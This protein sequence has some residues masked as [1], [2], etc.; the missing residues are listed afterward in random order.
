MSRFHFEQTQI[1]ERPLAEVFAFF[2]D[3][4]NLSRLTPPWLRFEILTP[5]PITMAPGLRLDYR[6]TLR[7]LPMKWQSEITE[8]EPPHR[9]VD[10]QRRGPYK[11]WIHE[12]RFRDLGDRTEV[13]DAVRYDV[14][15]GRI[16]HALFVARDIEKIFAYRLQALAGI[17]EG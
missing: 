7:G 10:E 8:W 14:P 17:F 1:V 12:H 16:V 6:I 4:R 11:T 2:S 3:A 15:G 13:T 9:F 5:E